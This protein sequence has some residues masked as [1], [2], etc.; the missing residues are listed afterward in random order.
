MYAYFGTD[1]KYTNKISPPSMLQKRNMY[2][3]VMVM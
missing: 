3:F 2:V 1:T